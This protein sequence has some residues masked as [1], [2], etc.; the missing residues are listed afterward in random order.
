MTAGDGNA[1]GQSPATCLARGM[2][3]C[4]GL[5][6]CSAPG[7]RAAV[8]H[9]TTAADCPMNGLAVAYRSTGRKPRGCR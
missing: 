2:L 1:G 4:K 7:L 9:G 5:M 3:G 8:A 6:M